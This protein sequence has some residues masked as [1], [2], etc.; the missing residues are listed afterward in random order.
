MTKVKAS[1][2]ATNMYEAAAVTWCIEPS[3]EASAV[4]N[5]VVAQL[6][7]GCAWVGE[8][9]GRV[10]GEIRPV[11]SIIPVSAFRTSAVTGAVW[12]A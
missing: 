6:H 2:A 1:I 8:D 9:M 4:R 3:P 11:T 10:S 5:Q 12:H 7:S